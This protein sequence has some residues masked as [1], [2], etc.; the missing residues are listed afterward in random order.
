MKSKMG[1]RIATFFLLAA[2]SCASAKKACPGVVIVLNGPSASGK[3]SI[4]K[5]FQ[6]LMLPNL[7]IKVGIDNLFDGPMPDITQE[8]LAYWQS[9]NSIRWVEESLDAEKNNV[10]TLCVGEQ[11]DKVAYGM[12]SAIADYAKNGC[13]VVVDYIAYKQEWLKDLEEKLKNIKTYYVAVNIPLE[14][15]EL[16]ESSRGTSPKGHARSHYYS[17]YGD[18]SYDLVVH[19]DKQT[20]VEIAKELRELIQEK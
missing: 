5:E 17:V 4:Q 13:N 16:R 6:V 2:S 15:L 9:K 7:W 3:S 14:V 19:S 18:I 12:N 11:G 10:I 8:N 20:A 1:V